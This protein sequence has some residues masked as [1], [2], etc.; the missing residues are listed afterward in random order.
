MGW[1]DLRDSCEP[2]NP[3]SA[4][5]FEEEKMIPKRPL[6]GTGEELS[7]IALGGI[8]VT[9]MPRAAANDLVRE[10]IERGI[11]YVDVAPTYGDAEDVLGPALKGYRDRVFLACKTTQRD[12]DGAAQELHR[13]LRK[14]GTD[15]FDLYQFHG[16]RSM[17]DVEMI[18]GPGGA[19][20]T[21]LEARERGLIRYI[22]FSA[23]SANAAL[24]ALDRFDFD[25]VLF[26]I[27]F[28]LY[29]RANFGPQVVE[30]AQEKGVARLA[31]KAMSK[32]QRPD[33]DDREAFPKCWYWPA[34]DPREASMALR[35]ALS[36]PITAAVPPGDEGLF[37]LAMDIASDFREITDE[38]VGELRRI[39]SG[40]KP[41]FELDL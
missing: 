28:T 18:F 10:A 39:A 12:R 19:V 1:T 21:F 38:E 13:S 7:I 22:G 23:H 6:G 26:P 3:H 14:L 24:A 16:L 32:G 41:I 2:P 15:R 25:T 40:Q 27:N 37:R 31:L 34:D 4:L 33:G 30:R 11:N 35:F 9:Q 20:E 29:F 36:Q 8:A 17:E 5:H